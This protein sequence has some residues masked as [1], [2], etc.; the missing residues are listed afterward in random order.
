MLE[1]LRQLIDDFLI[2]TNRSL[3]GW[4]AWLTE[5]W[6]QGS[7]RTLILLLAALAALA[8]F[9]LVRWL[10]NR[11]QASLFRRVSEGLAQ[12][13]SPDA[14][15]NLLLET[16]FKTTPANLAGLY[17]APTAAG[18]FPLRGNQTRS[19]VAA[20][21]LP[22]WELKQLLDT[23]PKVPCVEKHG[24]VRVVSLPIA[25]GGEEKRWSNFL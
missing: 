7:Y 14:V 17:L 16:I 3:Y 9:L 24:A 6:N 11:R 22:D 19:A 2:D 12:A 25:V 20:A 15:T 21:A 13:S 5:V 1:P 4:K 10:K 18:P 23:I 8:L